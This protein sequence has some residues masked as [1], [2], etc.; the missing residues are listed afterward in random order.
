M[1]GTNGLWA[2][3]TV[4]GRHCKFCSTLSQ[5]TC[6]RSSGLDNEMPVVVS[7]VQA[8][9]PVADRPLPHKLPHIPDVHSCQTFTI[10]QCSTCA[11]SLPGMMHGR[12][13]GRGEHQPHP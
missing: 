11:M 6:C 12:E 13:K 9:T 8:G 2:S 7:I 5:A 10:S 1:S 4:V 3:T